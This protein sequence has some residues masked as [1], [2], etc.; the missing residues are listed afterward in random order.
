MKIKSKKWINGKRGVASL[1]LGTILLT[2]VT[3]VVQAEDTQLPTEEIVTPN[4]VRYEGRSRDNVAEK[5]A[6]EQFS[7][8]N[9]VI[10]VNR[11]KFP[12]AISATNISQ[13]RYPVLYTREGSVSES[14]LKLLKSMTLD[15]IYV[16]GGTLSVNQSVEKQLKETV[17]VTVTRI[18]GRSRYDANVSAVEEN[19]TKTN[20]VVIASGEVYSDALYGVSYAN[21][22]DAPVVLANTNRLEA[23]TIELLKDLGVKEAT[24]IGGALTVT[25]AVETQLNELGIKHS[26][27]AGRNRYIG[28]AEVATASYKDPEN[29]VIASG[30]VFSDALVSAPL[31][32][33][34]NAPILLV[35]KDRMENVIEDYLRKNR[36]SVEN[37]YIQ[38]GPLTILPANENQFKKLTSY[39]RTTT[40]VPVQRMAEK[41][42]TIEEEDDTLPEG[43]TKVVQE[44]KNGY[45][46]INYKVTYVDDKETSRVEINRSETPPVSEIVKIGTQ[47][48]EV[49]EETI[50]EEVTFEIEKRYDFNG[51]EGETE[52]IKEGINGESENTYNVTYVNGVETERELIASNVILEPV[53]EVVQVGV[54]P[55]KISEPQTAINGMSLQIDEIAFREGENYNFISIEYTE[56]NNTEDFVMQNSFK[57]YLTNGE[58]LSHLGQFRLLMPGEVT[59]RTYL[60]RLSKTQMPK[61]LE[62]GRVYNNTKPNS[63]NPIWTFGN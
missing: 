12:D 2:S 32:Q 18:S 56:T 36:L 22:K 58:N 11:D 33:K 55:K 50:T 48:T 23:S 60:F 51:L 1:L 52:V 21:T 59:S 63:N 46:T 62:Y 24:I 20:H 29:I 28:S 40:I 41:Y 54:L 27:I 7:D 26:R 17:D 38:G 25:P 39:K 15:E 19:Y 42:Q 49:K 47:V 3:P 30:E 61:L 10:I 37:I 5:V 35:G 14:T 34:L 4:I 6:K 43:K 44:G 57:L 13:G 8:S 16:L 31:A 9:K 45:L 53:S